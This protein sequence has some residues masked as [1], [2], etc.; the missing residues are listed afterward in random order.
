MH[1]MLSTWEVTH[2]LGDQH[3]ILARKNNYTSVIEGKYDRPEVSGLGLSVMTGIG[4][5]CNLHGS[6]GTLQRLN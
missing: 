1:Y 3:I 5:N 4:E 6:S 2:S